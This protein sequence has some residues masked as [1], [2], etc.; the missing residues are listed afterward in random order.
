MFLKLG[1]PDGPLNPE[2]HLHGTAAR[3]KPAFIAQVLHQENAA[4]SAFFQAFQAGRIGHLLRVES[5]PFIRHPNGKRI[6][7]VAERNGNTFGAISLIAMQDS[8]GDGFRQTDK[9]IVVY[10]GRD[11]VALSYGV[12]KRFNFGYV[13]WVGR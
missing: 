6:S 5:G 13:I 4:T 2:F 10:I 12:H 11:F 9:D 7:L 3:G 8:V 1:G